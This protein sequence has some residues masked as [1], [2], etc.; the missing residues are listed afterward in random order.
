VRSTV[1]RSN[2]G[3]LRAVPVVIGALPA[4]TLVLND[5]SE[6]LPGGCCHAGWVSNSRPGVLIEDVRRF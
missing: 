5:P 6:T 2:S 4:I 3:P 1:R